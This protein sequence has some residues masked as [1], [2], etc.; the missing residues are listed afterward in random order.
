M[1]QRK[2]IF[3]ILLILILWCLPAVSVQAQNN[4]WWQ[5]K[6]DRNV[7][8]YFTDKNRPHQSFRIVGDI[9]EE[10]LK[11][12]QSYSN[13]RIAEAKREVIE[14]NRLG[15]NQS[16]YNDKLKE[17]KKVLTELKSQKQKTDSKIA[18]N[19]QNSTTNGQ[20]SNNGNSQF[21]SNV[22]AKNNY[23]GPNI[24]DS[25]PGFVQYANYKNA[26]VFKN[27]T[28]GNSPAINQ[29]IKGFV[30]SKTKQV[31]NWVSEKWNDWKEGATAIITDVTDV[32]KK[33]LGV[34]NPEEQENVQ[35]VDIYNRSQ[36]YKNT[37]EMQQAAGLN[38]ESNRNASQVYIGNSRNDIRGANGR[39]FSNSVVLDGNAHKTPQYNAAAETQKQGRDYFMNGNGLPISDNDR[40]R[41]KSLNTNLPVKLSN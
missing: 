40:K 13:N 21:G 12:Y 32:A 10:I 2:N 39:E 18:A 34:E 19:K 5:S 28:I 31:G 6:K 4:L 16:I 22:T 20:T 38:V 9:T 17:E 8:I 15:I 1:N 37:R 14:D 27:T 23:L 33:W 7:K 35:K 41:I 26:K 29:G 30:T 11:E 3:S 25:S 36:N 24:N